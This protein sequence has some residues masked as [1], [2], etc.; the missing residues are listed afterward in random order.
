MTNIQLFRAIG[1]VDDALLGRSER[2]V[3]NRRIQ[4]RWAP[5]ANLK[6]SEL[7][8][9]GERACRAI[10]EIRAERVYRGWQP[11]CLWGGGRRPDF[12]RR[13]YAGIAD[14]DTLEAV[15]AHIGRRIS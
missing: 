13:A 9:R 12:T 10:A 6:K 2:T 8:F 14:A 1:R 3:G 5:A 4:M 11:V 15:G 7:S